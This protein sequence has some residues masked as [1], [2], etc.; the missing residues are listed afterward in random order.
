MTH[1]LTG[2]SPTLSP[3]PRPAY[4]PSTFMPV[5]CTERISSFRVWASAGL[6]CTPWC[7]T[8]HPSG[9]SAAGHLAS[10]LDGL[11]RLSSPD[12]SRIGVAERHHPIR[13][14]PLSRDTL[15]GLCDD[16][17]YLRVR[18]DDLP[19]WSVWH[20]FWA[21]RSEHERKVARSLAVR[22]HANKSGRGQVRSLFRS[23]HLSSQP[24][25]R[26]HVVTP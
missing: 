11:L 18:E 12:G 14:R 2:S 22:S 4:T 21:G 19:T 25:R 10:K 7:S 23:Q 24:R 13:N 1:A 8:T 26:L 15:G 16:T 20:K 9:V 17:L 3:Y 6:P 5:C